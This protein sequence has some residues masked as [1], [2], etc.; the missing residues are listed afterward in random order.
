MCH[1]GPGLQGHHTINMLCQ[2]TKEVDLACVEAGCQP[3]AEVNLL[4][5]GFTEIF[6]HGG[7]DHQMQ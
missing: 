1:R 4:L 3:V 5:L 7:K 6:Y 2:L